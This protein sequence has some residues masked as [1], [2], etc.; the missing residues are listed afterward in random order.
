MDY[1]E[2]VQPFLHVS[3]NNIS[4][5]APLSTSSVSVYFI[6]YVNLLLHLL[7][8]P[9]CCAVEAS[10]PT[11]IVLAAMGHR[12]VAISSQYAFSQQECAGPL[13]LLSITLRPFRLLPLEM[14]ANSL[15]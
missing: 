4:G 15:N 2:E 10:S 1:V 5:P 14:A 8:V 11:T 12:I 13:R 6:V 7:R 9:L 3:A